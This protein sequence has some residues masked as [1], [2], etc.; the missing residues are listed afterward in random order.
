[1]EN[2]DANQE[3][4]EGDDEARLRE[5]LEAGIATNS[6]ADI[7]RMLRCSEG[8]AL[9]LRRKIAATSPQLLVASS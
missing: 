9:A 5:A 3:S 2:V 8:Q 6:I 4:A 7:T 1:V